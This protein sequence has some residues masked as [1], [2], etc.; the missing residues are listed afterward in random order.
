MNSAATCRSQFKSGSKAKTFDLLYLI[1]VAPT[2]VVCT[3]YI[4]LNSPAL[5]LVSLGCIF[6]PITGYIAVHYYNCKRAWQLAPALHTWLSANFTLLDTDE[7]GLVTRDDL[8]RYRE[9]ARSAERYHGAPVSL[10]RRNDREMAGHADYFLCDIGHVIK[11]V[12]VG[13]PMHGVVTGIK[14]YAISR[15]DVEGFP[16][17]ALLRYQR[18]F[19]RV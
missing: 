11:T 2:I 18:E 7:D 19:P 6:G 16:E 10:A 15:G 1:V 13:S 12:F 17:K 14:I 3:T 8:E 4:G 5:I 9:T